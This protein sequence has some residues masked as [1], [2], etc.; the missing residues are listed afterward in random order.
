MALTMQGWKKSA[1]RWGACTNVKIRM[2]GSG[3]LT[4]LGSVRNVNVSME[5]VTKAGDP[6]G[7]QVVQYLRYSFSFDLLQTDA[8]AELAMLAGT[9]GTGLFESDIEV[10]FTFA[11]GHSLTLGAVTGYTLRLVPGFQAGADDDVEFIPC[12]GECIEAITT[13]PAKVS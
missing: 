11:G 5:P 6:A 12:R 2:Q 3:T 4:S 10:Q 7:S 9:S 8:A 13:F 1:S